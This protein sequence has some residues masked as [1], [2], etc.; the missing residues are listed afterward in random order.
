MMNVDS[1]NKCRKI[2][3]L[4]K[5]DQHLLIITL[6]LK[7]KHLNILYFGYAT[8]RLVITIKNK[9]SSR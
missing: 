2:S 8:W 5:T 1:R 6:L 3:L 4:L 9:I 7:G